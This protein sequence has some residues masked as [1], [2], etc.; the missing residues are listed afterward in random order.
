MDSDSFELVL[1]GT[2]FRSDHRVSFDGNLFTT[3]FVSPEELRAA[4][5]GIALG[6]RARGVNVLALRVGDPPL[7]SNVLVFEVTEATP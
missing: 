7:R 6:S 4:V 3:T 1:H 2:D 5:L